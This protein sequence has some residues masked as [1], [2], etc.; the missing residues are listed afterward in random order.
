MDGC[1]FSGRLIGG[2]YAWAER[3]IE[4]SGEERFLPF[5]N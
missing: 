4:G 2:G 5:S 1:V 3:E